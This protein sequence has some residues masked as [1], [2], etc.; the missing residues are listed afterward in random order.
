MIVKE[1]CVIG[2]GLS[3]FEHRSVSVRFVD[4]D[5]PLAKGASYYYYYYYY[6]Y[7]IDEDEE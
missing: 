2:D 3:D 1:A 4:I 5:C 7:Y 6:Y